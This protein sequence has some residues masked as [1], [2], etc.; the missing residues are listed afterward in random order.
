MWFRNTSAKDFLTRTDACLEKGLVFAVCSCLSSSDSMNAGK[1]SHLVHLALPCTVELHSGE[2]ASLD[3]QLAPHND[4]GVLGRSMRQV[5]TNPGL[6]GSVDGNHREDDSEDQVHQCET[7][8]LR[9]ARYGIALAGLCLSLCRHASCRCWT[10]R[11]ARS[12][13][14]ICTSPRWRPTRRCR[15]KVGTKPV[16]LLKDLIII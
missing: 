1:V 15:C 14:G 7:P 6:N 3:R 11:G 4:H 8:R 10:P 12:A 16:F 9:L 13:A 2:E 5:T